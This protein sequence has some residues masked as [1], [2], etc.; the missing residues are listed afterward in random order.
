[1]AVVG[2]QALA[3]TYFGDDT[4][5]LY[6]TNTTHNTLLS[7]LFESPTVDDL[8]RVS[9]LCKCPPRRQPCQD[10]LICGHKHDSPSVSR[11]TPD[12]LALPPPKCHPT[13]SRH[14]AN[15][16]MPY[17]PLCLFRPKQV[18]MAQGPT[19]WEANIKL[20]RPPVVKIAWNVAVGHNAYHAL[21]LVRGLGAGG[22]GGDSV[23]CAKELTAPTA[24]SPQPF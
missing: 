7:D 3:A 24:V 2:G 22:P 19:G 1:M 21:R 10:R 20:V 16:A 8:D 12:S 9:L 17:W 6:Y 18:E 4:W 13:S 11:R 5:V 23:R 14:F 15:K